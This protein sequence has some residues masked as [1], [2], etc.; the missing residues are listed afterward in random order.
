M[1]KDLAT[2][3]SLIEKKESTLRLYSARSKYKCARPE[4]SALYNESGAMSDIL[5]FPLAIGARTSMF[6]DGLSR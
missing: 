1:A 3:V 2:V 4:E 6:Q 5:S